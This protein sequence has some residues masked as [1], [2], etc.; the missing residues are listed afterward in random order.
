[1]QDQLPQP[2]QQQPQA[3]LRREPLQQGQEQLQ[4]LELHPQEL[5]QPL[6]PQQ[7][8]QLAQ[9]QQQPPIYCATRQDE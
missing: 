5:R 2:G 9:Q 4:Q 6:Q 7:E 1:M 8:Q 3:F